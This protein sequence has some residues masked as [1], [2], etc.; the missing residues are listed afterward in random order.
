MWQRQWTDTVKGAVTRACFPSVRNRL[1]QKIAV[2]TE[3]TT[4]VTGRGKLISYLQ[5]FGLTGNLMFPC[6]EEEQTTNNIMFQC[7]KLHNQRNE[8]IKQIKKH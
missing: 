7:K 6:E 3:I 4:T 5:R 1:W 8:M 2:F